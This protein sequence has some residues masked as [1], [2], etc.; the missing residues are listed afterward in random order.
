[1]GYYTGTGVITGGSETVHP[2]QLVLFDGIYHAI[3]QKTRTKTTVKRGVRRETAIGASGSQNISN[4]VIYKLV[5][6]ENSSYSEYVVPSCMGT[7][8]D[9]SFSQI[10][11]SNLYELAETETRLQIRDNGGSWQ[12]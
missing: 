11:G 1:M 4:Y 5:T 9:V 7:K 2:L 6:G 10:N 12:G 8:T 3:D